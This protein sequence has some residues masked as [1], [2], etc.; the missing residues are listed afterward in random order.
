M[1]EYLFEEDEMNSVVE[2]DEGCSFIL[3]H[4]AISHLT[5][6]KKMTTQIFFELTAKSNIMN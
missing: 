1:K 2:I 5:Y 3:V 4:V 6:L